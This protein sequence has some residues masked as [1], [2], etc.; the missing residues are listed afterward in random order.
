M[1]LCSRI[2]DKPPNAVWRKLGNFQRAKPFAIRLRGFCDVTDGMTPENATQIRTAVTT[3][4]PERVDYRD[5][6]YYKEA[7]TSMRISKQRFREDG[8]LRPF[9]HPRGGFNVPNPSNSWAMRDQENPSAGWPNMDIKQTPSLAPNDWYGVANICD[10][11]YFG[12]RDTLEMDEPGS[13]TEVASVLER[14]TKYLPIPVGSD[15]DENFERYMAYGFKQ[16]TADLN[17]EMKKVHTIVEKWLT[18]LELQL[19]EKGAKEEFL[20]LLGSTFTGT[21]RHVEWRGVE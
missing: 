5:R 10:A 20:M 7:S 21:E 18:R 11:Y 16:I 2:A 13:L 4:A 15:V 8:L 3:L 12:I 9:G 17:V 6:W 1:E 19:G 14:T